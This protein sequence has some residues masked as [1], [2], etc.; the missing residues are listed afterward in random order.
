M[1]LHPPSHLSAYDRR[2]I[3][4]SYSLDTL[5][6]PTPHITHVTMGDN[7]PNDATAALME[8]VR[9]MQLAFDQQIQQ[10]NATA[11]AQQ[12]HFQH[13]IENMRQQQYALQQQLQKAQGAL[14]QAPPAVPQR[15]PSIRIAAPPTYDG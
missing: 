15:G 12:Q 6:E 5:T 11:L 14:L 10:G 13:E 4:A 1:I 2:P 8:Q 3:D 7:L 9:Q